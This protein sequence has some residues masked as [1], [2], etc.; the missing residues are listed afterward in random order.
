MSDPVC[1]NENKHSL[2]RRLHSKGDNDHSRTEGELGT[3]HRWWHSVQVWEGTDPGTFGPV[4]LTLSTV[5][6]PDHASDCFL[7]GGRTVTVETSTTGCMDRMEVEVRW[8]PTP[9]PRVVVGDRSRR[10]VLRSGVHRF[11]SVGPQPLSSTLFVAPGTNTLSPPSTLPVGVWMPFEPRFSFS[12]GKFLSGRDGRTWIRAS[13]ELFYLRVHPERIYY[14]HLHPF[15]AWTVVKVFQGT[16]TTE[17]FWGN[18]SHSEV[19]EEVSSP[20]TWKGVPPD[21][22]KTTQKDYL[23]ESPTFPPTNISTV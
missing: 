1:V 10:R 9:V 23:S 3:E 2:L 13:T 6:E 20:D 14:I 22:P 18:W 4:W 19:Q 16:T 7:G 21:L 15:R 11:S 17:T 8:R 5:P 12:G